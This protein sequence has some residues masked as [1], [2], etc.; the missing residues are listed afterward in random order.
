MQEAQP[1]RVAQLSDAHLSARVPGFGS[2]FAHAAAIV[3]AAAPDL[4][5]ATGDLSLD[6][7]GT[8]AELVAA[9]DAHAC[10][11]PDWAAV[12]GNHD[13]GDGPAQPPTP[14]R[15]A[16][17]EA[18]F[19]PRRFR[20]DVPGWRLL[21]LDAQALEE[22][23]WDWLAR[24]AAGAPRIALFLHKPVML[25]AMD[26]PDGPWALPRAAR[27]RLLGLLRPA[28]IACGHV[29]Q[30]RDHSPAG[31]RQIWAPATSFILGDRW[32]RRWGEKCLGWMEHILHADGRAE[33]ILHRLPAL[34][35]HDLGEMPAVYGP[36]RPLD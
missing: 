8:P 7:A 28:F 4:L 34:T 22:A 27:E 13:V 20:R 2:N 10:L 14:A 23:Q 36:H 30:A 29:H 15:L 24:Q 32:Q 25:E 12:P 31:L 35:L 18:A 16:A 21:G 1:F 6:G 5:V 9:R 17:W 3:R 26:E 19:G 33:H 11:A